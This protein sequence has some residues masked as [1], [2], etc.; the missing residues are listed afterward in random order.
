VPG[1]SG[2]RQ[3]RAAV[4]SGPGAVV[5]EDVPEPTPAAGELLIE[6]AYAAIC[7]TDASEYG[8]G[9][10]L[11]PLH[12]PHPVTGHSGPTILGHEFVG[13]VVAANQAP[14]FGVGDR[15]VSGAGASCGDCSWC[16]EGRTNLCDRY[17][18][19]GI[20][21]HG[22]LAERVVAPAATCRRVPDLLSDEQAVL[23]Q[24]L[25]V[26][27]HAVS[28]A[29]VAR[30]D[31]LAVIGVG[32]I[33]AFLVAAARHRG[34][35]RIFAVDIDDRRLET[36]AA[37]GADVTINARRLDPLTAILDATGG[38]GASVVA[39]VSGAASS[40][41]LA[42]A[43]TRRGGRI[44]LVALHPGETALPL[45]DLNLGEIDIITTFA[46]VCGDD[47]PE[48]LDVLVDSDAARH[49]IG[50]VIPLHRVVEDGF[51]VLSSGRASGKILVRVAAEA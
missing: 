49:V 14:G 12:A 11:V 50:D 22:G 3:V 6:V 18:T 34:V 25:A 40:F 5:I 46:H 15:V 33:G 28:R 39:E 36:A 16:R 17:Y 30:S 9:P 23:A 20:H 37:L 47:L 45:L 31:T 21:T 1:G 48:A 26:A 27:V 29:G 10:L 13:R 4:Y 44:L 51:E 24:P 19:I 7:G 41:P 2:R 42:L 35:E 32:G 43:A 38:V 8:H